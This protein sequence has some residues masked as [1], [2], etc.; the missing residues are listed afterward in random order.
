MTAV[1][2]FDV[3]ARY[4]FNA[5]LS[6]AVEIIYCLMALIVFLGLGLVTF[7]QGHIRVDVLTSL[8]P[9]KMQALCDAIVNLL[10]LT[11]AAL[12]AWRLMLIAADQIERGNVSMVMELPIWLVALIAALVS[13]IF[14][15]CLLWQFGSALSRLFSRQSNQ[16]DVRS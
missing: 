1:V 11:I 16:T 14:V 5:P 8:M 9:A 6:G 12:I 2:L 7:D 3:V 10:S 4:F 15:L 13:P